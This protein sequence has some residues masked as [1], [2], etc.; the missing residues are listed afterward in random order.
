MSDE[1]HLARTP[2]YD[3]HGDH[4]GRLAEFSGWAMPIQYESIV[5]EL[6]ATRNSIG[7]FDISHM[8][9]LLIDGNDATAF[10]ESLLTRRVADMNPGQVRYSLLCNSHG[11]ILD[12]VLVYQVEQLD[13]NLSGY[14]LVVNAGNRPKIVAWLNEHIGDAD[15]EIDD[16]TADYAMIAVQGPR[17]IELLDPITDCELTALRYYHGAMARLIGF[18]CFVSRTGYTGEDGCEVVCDAADA[19]EIW[20]ALIERGATPVGLG[21]R[22]TL[23]L[24]AGMPLYGHELSEQIDPLQAGLGFAVNLRDRRFVGSDSIAEFK[25]TG[26]ES[27]R[28]GLQ[29]EGRRAAREE[30]PVLQGDERVGEVT[31]GAFSPTFDRA[32]AMAYVKTTAAA[33]GTSLA[34]EVRGKQYAA[35]V[36]PLPFYQRGV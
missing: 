4:G 12:D 6:L 8:G 3:W 30:A 32:I 10:L 13:G 23:R 14:G 21:A 28:I 33:P 27:V 7:L 17:A 11:G 9:R 19:A 25:Q 5:S 24:E 20:E 31:S 35:Q 36:V 15:V 16:K 1:P 2:L 18:R 34:V 22:D 26:R 29:L